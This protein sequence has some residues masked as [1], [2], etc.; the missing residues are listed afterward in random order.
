MQTLAD[1]PLAS[2]EMLPTAT[3]E[4]VDGAFKGNPQLAGVV[5]AGGEYDGQVLTRNAFYQQMSRRTGFDLFARRPITAVLQVTPLFNFELP[6]E[7]PVAEAVER[8]MQR[9]EGQTYEPIC[10]RQPDGRLGLVSFNQLV[11][12]QSATLETMMEQINERNRQVQDSIRYAERIQHS[13]I[14]SETQELPS[15][16]DYF[17]IY[18]PRDIVSGDF[19]WIAEKEGYLFVAVADCTGHGVP[20][21]FMSLIGHGHLSSL[22]QLERLKDPAEILR[23]LHLRIRR[24]LHQE[25]ASDVAYDGMEIALCVV[26]RAAGRLRFSGAKRPLLIVHPDGSIENYKGDRAAIGGR[27]RERERSFTTLEFPL[28][29]G[30]TYIQYSDGWTDQCDPSGEKFGTRRLLEVLAQVA[31]LTLA[32]QRQFLESTLDLFQ[33]SVAQ[34]DDIALL[35][36]RIE[37]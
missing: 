26:D 12:A 17:T 33:K 35:G 32:E 24:S 22:V 13:M 16:L 15:Y 6:A 21:A 25:R 4:E 2:V 3:G 9:G 31:P 30:A 10:V 5:M 20:G 7:T 34:R 37:D 18:R 1:L 8:S 14:F 23:Q 29:T 11:L 19:Y 28:S 36:F 27:Q